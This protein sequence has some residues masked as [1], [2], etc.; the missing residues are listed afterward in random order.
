MKMI[1]RRSKQTRYN[2]N[3]ANALRDDLAKHPNPMFGDMLQDTRMTDGDVIDFALTM[4][5]SY[6][7][8]TLLESFKTTERVNLELVTRR[9]LLVT[10]SL[11]GMTATFDKGGAILTPVWTDDPNKQVAAVQALVDTGMGVKEAMA[12]F[13]SGPPKQ[14]HMAEAI[15]TQLPEAVH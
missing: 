14:G 1:R 9:T 6:F 4:A 15:H 2:P 3:R 8:G 10:A 11:F 7:S 12:L 13:A 5:H